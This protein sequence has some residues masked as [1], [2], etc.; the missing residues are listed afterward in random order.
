MLHR[1]LEARCGRDRG[2]FAPRLVRNVVCMVRNFDARLRVES[3]GSRVR[4]PS[5]TLRDSTVHV[6]R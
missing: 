5:A 1:E 3:S 6:K 2:G 4:E